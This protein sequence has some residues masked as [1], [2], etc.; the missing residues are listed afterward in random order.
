MEHPIQPTNLSPQATKVLDP[1]APAQLKMM[2]AS[3]LAPIPPG[4]LVKVLYCL[5]YNSD[6]AMGQKARESLTKLPENILL[7]SVE[8]DL[9]EGVLD[10]VAH[11]LIKRQ[12]VIDRII[13]NQTT[14]GSTIE[15]LTR[16]LRTEASLELVA[17]NESRLLAF[18]KII[19]ALYMNSASR[20]STVDRVVELAVRNG[21]ELNGIP[22]FA[23]AKA[24]IEGQLIMEPDDEPSPEDMEFQSAL[25]DETAEELDVEAVHEILSALEA[26]TSDSEF[27]EEEQKKVQ[28]FEASLAG[29]GVSQKIRIAMLGNSSQRAIL[30]RDSNKLVIMSVLKSPGIAESEV[31]MYSKARSLPEEAVRYIANKKDWTKA[32]QVKLNLVNN[33]RTPLQDALRFLNHLRP[34]DI[35]ALER[36]RDVPQGII[37]AAKQLRKKRGR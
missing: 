23:E 5:S 35:R 3:G 4:D 12:D 21:I 28:T 9:G 7:S 37:N 18:P 8:Q 26:G 31:I 1:G 32:Y 14:S 11:I 19:E 36:S 13:L 33:P 27:E 16:Q 2:A 22:T 10:G 24:A 17:A 15:W 34:N 20:M 6:Q 29:L 30:I 25:E